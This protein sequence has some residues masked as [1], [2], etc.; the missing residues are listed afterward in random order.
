MFSRNNGGRI[1][2]VNYK[3]YHYGHLALPQGGYLVLNEV[4]VEIE[5]G[6][7][8]RIHHLQAGQKKALHI[9]GK[10]IKVRHERGY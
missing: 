8:S 9:E 10:T 6:G 1:T 7:D 2:R 3:I 5:G 4:T